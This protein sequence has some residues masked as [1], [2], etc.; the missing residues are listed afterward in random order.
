MI[1][2]RLAERWRVWG[3][4]RV[5]EQS[6]VRLIWI[7]NRN[8]A[9]GLPLPRPFRAGMISPHGHGQYHC[10][11]LVPERPDSED[12]R[13]AGHR[14]VIGPEPVLSIIANPFPRP[15]SHPLFRHGFHHPDFRL[16]FS[17]AFILRS[18]PY[19]MKLLHNSQD[20]YFSVDPILGILAVVLAGACI[21]LYILF[22]RKPV[23]D[24]PKFLIFSAILFLVFLTVDE[25]MIAL[26]FYILNASAT[27]V[28]AGL[29]AYGFWFLFFFFQQKK[30][31]STI[32]Y[33]HHHQQ[34]K[35]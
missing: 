15:N 29:A 30:T 2:R 32:K 1:P 10:D 20:V 16:L 14:S 25:R 22:I 8:D 24:I 17:A 9:C 26:S 6:I 33:K 28:F 12:A 11:K 5:T 13:C 34:V 23:P 7:G 27:G 3:A 31:S 35:G 21:V 4:S 18:I 19:V